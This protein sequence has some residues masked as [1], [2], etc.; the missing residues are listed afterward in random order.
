MPGWLEGSHGKTSGFESRARR[1]SQ[2]ASFTALKSLSLVRWTANRTFWLTTR[3]GYSRKSS[4]LLV[5]IV[6][7]SGSGTSAFGGGALACGFCEQAASNI[8]TGITKSFFFTGEPPRLPH[9]LIRQKL[10]SLTP[11][12]PAAEDVPHDSC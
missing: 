1:T 4:P 12:N 3:A 8:A 6:A 5:Q 10:L 11:A 7:R 9:A 2:E